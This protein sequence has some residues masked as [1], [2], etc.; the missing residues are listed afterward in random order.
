MSSDSDSGIGAAIIALFAAGPATGIF[1]YGSIQAKYRNRSA[2]YMP[3]RVVKYEAKNMEIQDAFTGSITS[4]SS[5]ISGRNERDHATR[6]A[7]VTMTKD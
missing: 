6:A 2:R 3:E 4:H 1:V 5:S 7:H